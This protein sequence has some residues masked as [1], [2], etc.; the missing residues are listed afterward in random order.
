MQDTIP[1]KKELDETIDEIYNVYTKY[2][3]KEDVEKQVDDVPLA[4]L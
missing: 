3:K 4:D 2:Q 1:I